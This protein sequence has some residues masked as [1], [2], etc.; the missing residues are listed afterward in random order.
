MAGVVTQLVLDAKTFPLFR[1][2]SGRRDV[3]VRLLLSQHGTGNGYRQQDDHTQWMR[4]VAGRVSPIHMC[5]N[6]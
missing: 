5:W 4:L 6:A 3:L 1:F 2:R